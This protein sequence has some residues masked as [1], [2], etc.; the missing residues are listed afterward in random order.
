MT[1]TIGR[2]LLSDTGHNANIGQRLKAVEKYLDGEEVFLAN[3]ADVLT[4][5]NLPDL[6]EF[7]RRQRAT[8]TFLCVRTQAE[9][10]QGRSG[11]R[12]PRE[13]DRVHGSLRHLDQW[14]LLRHAPRD[15]RLHRGRRRPG[16][17]AL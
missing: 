1:M 2:S 4:D 17:G 5:V 3:Y 16:G 9:P 13:P 6:V 12:R 15:L 14:R 11:F 7:A 8:A 10:A